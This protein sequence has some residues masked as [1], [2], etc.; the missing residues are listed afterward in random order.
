MFKILGKIKL[1]ITA[2]LLIASLN[3]IASAESYYKDND[4]YSNGE[5]YSEAGW[6]LANASG[7]YYQYVDGRYYPLPSYAYV[8]GITPQGGSYVYYPPVKKD[9]YR[10][11]RKSKKEIS[12]K[13]YPLFFDE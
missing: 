7:Y 3:N 11:E 9:N 6:Q 1:A 12:A 13:N 4:Y 2:F 10:H 8:Y 5:H